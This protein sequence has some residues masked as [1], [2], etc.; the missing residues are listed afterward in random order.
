MEHSLEHKNNAEID[1][2]EKWLKKRADIR[3]KSMWKKT[4]FDM[5]S[6]APYDQGYID[7]LKQALN[8]VQLIK[9]PRE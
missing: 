2:V 7:G 3:H 1:R 9:T 6:H 5:R 4:S 8:F